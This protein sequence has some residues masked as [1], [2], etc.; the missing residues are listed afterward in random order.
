[1]VGSNSLHL[2]A[3]LPASFIGAQRASPPSLAWPGGAL[4]LGSGSGFLA[5]PGAPIGGTSYK[6]AQEWGQPSLPTLNTETAVG[7]AP[8]AWKG[9]EGPTLSLP[10]SQRPWHLSA[11]SIPHI[12]QSGSDKPMS[13]SL[14]SLGRQPKVGTAAE[15]PAH[16]PEPH[17]SL[18]ISLLGLRN[19]LGSQEAGPPYRRPPRGW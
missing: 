18:L 2:L 14:R 4:A 16:S 6:K 1:M 7:E 12:P 8:A 10:C 15:L 3:L 13:P 9:R 19:T 17:A 5:L 11:D